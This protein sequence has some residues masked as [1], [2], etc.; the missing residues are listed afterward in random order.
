MKIKFFCPIWGLVPDY[1]QQVDGSLEAI[2]DK[3]KQAGYDGIEMAIPFNDRQKHEINTLKK[4]HKLNVVALQYAANG[5]TISDFVDS[6]TAHI[7]S[8]CDVEPILINSHTGSDFFTFENNCKIIEQSLTLAEELNIKLVHE[9]HRGRFSFHSATLQQYLLAYPKLRLTADFSHW[10]NV[11]ESF[12]E[13]QSENISRAIERSDHLHSRIGHPQSCQ[14]NDPRAPE[15]KEA[16]DHHLGWWDQIIANHQ[17]LGTECFTITP[18][19]GPANYMPTLPYTLQ[20]VA[21]QWD[22]NAWM[23]DLLKKRYA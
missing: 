11:S 15:W 20:P 18:E 16:M 23:M 22:I 19:F 14:V 21:S 12:L 9:T 1:I 5:E 6:Y 7:K 8:A 4:S 10:C 2:F 17:S 3:V 13:N